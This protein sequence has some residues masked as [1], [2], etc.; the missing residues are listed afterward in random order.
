M[1]RPREAAT[2]AARRQQRTAP[3]APWPSRHRSPPRPGPAPP[4]SSA[5]TCGP[6][7]SSPPPPAAGRR[8]LRRRHAWD[9]GRCFISIAQHAEQRRGG[10]Q[11]GHS[12][13]QELP[14]PRGLSPPPHAHVLSPEPWRGSDTHVGPR[15]PPPTGAAP[16]PP[17]G[18]RLQSSHPSRSPPVPAHFFFFS[19]VLVNQESSS[20]LL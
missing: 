12:T 4:H 18:A 16:A 9:R 20:F 17:H 10:G 19:C 6:A 7:T 1:S 11:R 15:G 2:A 3:G 13:A 5:G 8:F 14:Q